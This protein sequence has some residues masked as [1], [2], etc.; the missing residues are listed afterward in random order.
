MKVRKLEDKFRGIE[1]H[2]VLRKDN[3]DAKALTKMAAQR[4]PAHSGV[5]VNNL[6]HL[7]SVLSQIRLQG[8][9]IRY[10]GAP[11]ESPPNRRPPTKHLGAPTALRW[12]SQL[13][14]PM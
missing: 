3:N 2:H 9:P 5:F 4:D 12:R 6:T 10:P 7:R 8:H 1:L 14:R 11:A 13:L